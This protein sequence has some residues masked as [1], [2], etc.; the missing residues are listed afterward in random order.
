MDYRTPAD[1]KEEFCAYPRRALILTTVI[2]ESRSVK[3]HLTNPEMLIGDKSTLYEYGRFSDPAGDWLVVHAIT[4]QGNSD[5]GL[6]ASEAHQEFGC[7]HALMF[8]GVGGSLK[9]DI[10]I[11]SVVVGDYVYNGHSAKI[12][13]SQTLGRPHG[14]VPSLELLT[15]A[16]ALIY[17]EEWID[18]IR[19]PYRMELPKLADYPC[20]FPP[21][22]VIKGI[23]S[24]E[25]VV[26]GDKSP[27][28]IWLRTHFNDCGAV[29]MEGW[30]V[31]SAARRQNTP[32]LIIRGISD[33]CAGKDHVKDKLHQPIAAAHAAA[34]AFSILSFRS[35]VLGPKSS[36]LDAGAEKIVAEQ[37][38]EAHS[39]ED[40]RVEF[41]FNFEG[42]EDEWSEEKIQTVV[43]LLKQ[44]I[45]DENLN[46]VRIEAGSVR[47]VMSVRE[48]DLATMDLAKLR[49]VALDSGVT[50]LG[51]MPLELMSEA[52]NAKAALSAASVDLLVWEKTLPNGRWMER[53]ELEC[54]FRRT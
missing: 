26:A 35:K 19:A 48:S 15:A 3:A 28:F 13:D 34:F 51:A 4:S 18:L 36:L 9:E 14:L 12:E 20:E 54:A 53:P 50:L 52:E 43:D 7:F 38:A 17:T 45:G 5:V 42:S 31:M 49:G 24:G 21:S 10:L 32:A 1:V 22:A 39:P 30:G 44:K 46:L 37:T 25:E 33:M 23:V 6:V 16:Q 11:G 47:L 29:E 41:V 8:V 40:R 2:H 27:R